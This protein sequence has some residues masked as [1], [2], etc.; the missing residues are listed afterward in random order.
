MS[1]SESIQLQTAEILYIYSVYLSCVQNHLQSYQLYLI[2][3]FRKLLCISP[4]KNVKH[5]FTL[6]LFMFEININMS[7]WVNAITVED[8]LAKKQGNTCGKIG[9]SKY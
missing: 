1:D 9:E 8:T 5:L 4:F 7:G 2:R 3:N 6:I